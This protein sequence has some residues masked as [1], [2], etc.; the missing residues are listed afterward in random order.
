MC[1]A[2]LIFSEYLA[3]KCVHLNIKTRM[4]RPTM[5]DFNSSELTYYPLIISLDK[6][7]GSFNAVDFFQCFYWFQVKYVRSCIDEPNNMKDV[8]VQ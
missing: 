4:T 5:I 2:L 6:R 7:N 1:I 3:T 8:N